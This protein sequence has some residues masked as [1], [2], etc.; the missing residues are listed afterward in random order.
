MRNKNSKIKIKALIN[1]AANCVI[2]PHKNPDGD[3]LGSSLALNHF[4][5]YK[6]LNS[7]VISPSEY[8]D[9]L[10]WMPGENQIM[11]YDKEKESS[12]LKIKKA[13]LIFTLDFN[14]L[15]R[16]GD[17]GEKIK[18]SKGK[19]VMI[20][21]HEN[22]KN[23]AHEMISQPKIGS[24]CEIIYDLIKFIDVKGINSIVASCLYTGIMTDSGSFRY[25]STT[26]KTH[27]I[28]SDL[29]NRGAKNFEIHEKI[30]DTFSHNRLKLLGI[31]LKNIEKIEYFPYVI[32]TLNQK[33]LDSCSFKKGDTEGFVNYG[34]N[35][36]GISLSIILIENKKENIVKLSFRSKGDFFTNIFAEK[37][38]EGGGHQNASG[39]ISYESLLKT[40]K[41]LIKLLK[42]HI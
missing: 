38:F 6:G 40:K 34:L 26:A 41:R 29:I 31:A 15:S 18:E 24:T 13:D 42:S 17:M 16:A 25:P 7:L 12:I 11:N 2:I 1:E 5:S 8:P 33:E 35:I 3:A 23:Y 21:H 36:K 9:F 30:Y 4:L 19:I 39:G 10:K 20:D 14:D 22:P 37:Y 32:I 28:I 27:K